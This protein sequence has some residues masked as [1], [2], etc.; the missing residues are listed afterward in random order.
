MQNQQ[1]EIIIGEDIAKVFE[2]DNGIC[3]A[4]EIGKLRKKKKNLPQVHITD[5]IKIKKNTY[6]IRISKKAIIK[7]TAIKSNNYSALTK[8]IIND[9]KEIF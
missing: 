8:E 2:K 6:E 5:E 7:K 4:N 1:L 3:L 9:L